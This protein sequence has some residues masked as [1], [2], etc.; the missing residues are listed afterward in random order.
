V[1]HHINIA[2]AVRERDEEAA[3]TAMEAHLDYLREHVARGIR[4]AEAIAL[5]T[6][7]RA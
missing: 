6:N 3:A 2:S 5:G 1:I 4:N 7:P